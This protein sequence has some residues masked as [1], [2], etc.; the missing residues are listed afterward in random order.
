VALGRL[1]EA[2]AAEAAKP[3]APRRPRGRPDRGVRRG[4]VRVE[5]Y[6]QP[7]MREGLDR[8]ADRRE[9][10]TGKSTRRSGIVREAL[11]MYLRQH[12]PDASL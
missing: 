4:F 5:V 8:L 3:A 7:A 2:L 12:L 10:Q 1:T 6:L 9:T 11:V